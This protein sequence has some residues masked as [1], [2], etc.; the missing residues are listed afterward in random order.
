ME[1]QLL[2]KVCGFSPS[3]NKTDAPTITQDYNPLVRVPSI[4]QSNVKWIIAFV[5][6]LVVVAMMHG[7]PVPH[8][9]EY[10]YLLKAY[11]TWHPD[12]LETDWTFEHTGSEHWLFNR[13]FG[14]LTLVLPL[15]MVG[16]LGRLATWVTI[17]WLLCLIARD[18]KLSPWAA[19]ISIGAWVAIGQSLMAESWVFGGFEAKCVAYA[20]LLASLRA[21]GR[22]RLDLSAAFIGLAFSFHPSVGAFGAVGLATA[23]IF[24]AQGLRGLARYVIVA[25]VTGLPG[26]VMVLPALASSATY[27]GNA[28]YLV[29][30]RVPHHLDALSWPKAAYVTLFMALAFNSLYGWIKRS[31]GGP[32][33]HLLGFQLGITAVFAIGVLARLLSL[34][35]L[36]LYFPFRLFP[37]FTPLLFFFF[38]SHLVERF[39]GCTHRVPFA[40]LGLL[41]L[42]S[43]PNPFDGLHDGTREMLTRWST[44]PTELATALNW[45]RRS[46]EDSARLIA[47]PWEKSVWYHSHRATVVNHMYFPYEELA[48]WRQRS[49]LVFGDL[50]HGITWTEMHAQMEQGYESLSPRKVREISNRYA[51][52]YI[53]TRV[54]YPFAELHRSGEY[55]VYRVPPESSDISPSSASRHVAF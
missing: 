12:F 49:A 36:L 23:L 30:V 18:L 9:N 47:P 44:A 40:A 43:F 46:V 14:A 28:E 52:K 7:Y 45:T 37:L 41:T 17:S 39:A 32:L 6:V 4:N 25:L 21:V 27:V 34:H 38:L 10:V 55:R 29:F 15:E 22:G 51:A 54:E 33:L 31:S 24:S 13:V 50:P 11:Q 53:V 1:T 3:Q 5:I 48:E 20:F 42:M 19:A 2:Q 16:W 26:L 8:E 35:G